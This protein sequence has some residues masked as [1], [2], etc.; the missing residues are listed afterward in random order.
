MHDDAVGEVV[1]LK[2]EICSE[3]AKLKAWFLEQLGDM[4]DLPAI[5]SDAAPTALDMDEIR[6]L[7]ADA[8]ATVLSLIG[9]GTAPGA[10]Q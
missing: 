10:I 2:D 5:L 9:A 8:E 3:D 6:A 4:K 1:R 7:L